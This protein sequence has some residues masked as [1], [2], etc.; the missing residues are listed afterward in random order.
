MSG[1]ESRL[2]PLQQRLLAVLCSAEPRGIL[3]GG[4]A[5]AGFHTFHR[6]TKDLDLFW[7]GLKQLGELPERA[8]ERVRGAGLQVDSLQSY[9]TFHRLRVTDGG[10][11]CVV[12]LVVDTA[13]RIEA[14]DE[15][16]I[17]G[18]RVL[19]DTPHEILVNK[20]CTL[21]SRSEARDL[22]DVRVL[23]ESGGDFRR[24]LAEA[25]RKDGGF[26]APTLAWVLNGFRAGKMA[27]SLGWS[28][29]ASLRLEEFKLAFIERL[30]AESKP[31][32]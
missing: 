16:E 18:V 28:Q 14:P 30:L 31:P 11:T 4:A 6:G 25:P 5:L 1:P 12:D 9:P 26:S 13:E 29:E 2:S 17:L 23:L 3:T 19:V 22:E 27:E 15:R 20:L 7:Y 21:L 32:S 10:E 24:A 8:I